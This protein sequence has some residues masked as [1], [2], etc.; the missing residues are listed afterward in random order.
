[1]IAVDT[2]ALLA[3]VFG[4]PQADACMEVLESADGVCMSSATLAEALIVAGRRNVRR[5]VE[6]L[7]EEFRIEILDVTA[8]TSRLVADAYDLW[9]RGVHPATLNYGDCF[10]YE[11]ARSRRCPLLFVGEDFSKTDI[12]PA[13]TT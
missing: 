9:G 2:S 4:E 7:V 10:A 13:L 6:G 1:M 3:I 11:T 12:E 5:V 8:E